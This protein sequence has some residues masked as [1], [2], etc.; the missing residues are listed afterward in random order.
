MID[1]SERDCVFPVAV[2]D[3]RALH[4]LQRAL[5]ADFDHRSFCFL[6][7]ADFLVVELWSPRRA[8]L[9]FALRLRL[10]ILRY[11]Q[12][13]GRC[14]TMN[15]TLA[16]VKISFVLWP[17]FCRMQAASFFLSPL[18]LPVLIRASLG[19]SGR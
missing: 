14:Q 19:N 16:V 10:T 11:G 13:A 18:S 7:L 1:G 6:G 9:R 17:T 2:R 3:E 8:T 12:C 15:R 5:V 4:D